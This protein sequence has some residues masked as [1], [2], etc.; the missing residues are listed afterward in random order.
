M[1]N[2]ASSN[3]IKAYIEFL[4]INIFMQIRKSN[5]K[6]L[7]LTTIS[8]KVHHGNEYNK[9]YYLNF[10]ELIHNLIFNTKINLWIKLNVS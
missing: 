10:Q 1:M 7:K 8:I 4:M 6:Q 9:H 3:F 5:N 2:K